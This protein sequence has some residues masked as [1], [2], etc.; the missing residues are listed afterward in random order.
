MLIYN[1]TTKL[2]WAIENDWLQW[3]KTEHLPAV[4]AAGNFENHQLVKLLEADDGDGPTYAVQ[5]YVT[6]KKSLDLYLDEYSNKFRQE[7]IDRWGEKFISFKSIME[8]I[9]T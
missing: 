1:I 2:Y 3:M 4:M 5:F 9:P 6:D 8:V 7:A